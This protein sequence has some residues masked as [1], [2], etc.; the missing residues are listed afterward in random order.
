MGTRLRDG[1]GG[2]LLGLAC[3][4]KPALVCL[5]PGALV[6]VLR[7][8]RRRGPAALAGLALPLAL[9]A[10]STSTSSARRR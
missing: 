8:A 1:A 10:A 6:L 5:L 4:A 9:G 2:A 7:E 3:L